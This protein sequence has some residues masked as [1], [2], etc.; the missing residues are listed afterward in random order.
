MKREALLEAKE[1]EQKRK[2]EN[3]KLIKEK[4]AEIKENEDKLN[5]KR[6]QY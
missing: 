5:S 2:I 3:D 6:K 4:K 1:E